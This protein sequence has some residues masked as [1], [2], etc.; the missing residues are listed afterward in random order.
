MILKFKQGD[1]WTYLAIKDFWSVSSLTHEE[2]DKVLNDKIEKRIYTIKNENRI[3]VFKE[4]KDGVKFE[5]K[6]ISLQTP[7]GEWYGVV[8]N[9][10]AYILNENGRTIEKIN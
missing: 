9:N 8:T 10:E 4:K 7:S 5:T 6:V 2:S 3:T 1:E